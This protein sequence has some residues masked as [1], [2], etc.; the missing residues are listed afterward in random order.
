MTLREY[1]VLGAEDASEDEVGRT[2]G[3]FED[4]GVR[5]FDRFEQ[6]RKTF[7]SEKAARPTRRRRRRP[8]NAPGGTMGVEWRA[9]RGR[10]RAEDEDVC[11]FVTREVPW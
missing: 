3:I 1:E 7:E 11:L 5:V 6:V 10:T 9:R 2:G 4:V 8:V